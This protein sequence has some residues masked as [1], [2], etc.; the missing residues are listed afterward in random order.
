[1]AG[2]DFGHGHALAQTFVENQAITVF[3]HGDIFIE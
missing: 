1:L 2:G 3:V